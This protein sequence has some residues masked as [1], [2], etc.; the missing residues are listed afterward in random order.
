MVFYEAPKKRN[1]NASD[2]NYVGAIGR[3]LWKVLKKFRGGKVT[4]LAVCITNDGRGW[5]TVDPN[6][7]GR[8]STALATK[9]LAAN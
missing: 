9:V 7:F 6:L 8:L 4:N 1:P 3:K 2:R 5:L